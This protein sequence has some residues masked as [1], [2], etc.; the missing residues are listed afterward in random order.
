MTE[1]NFYR[2]PELA[3]RWNRTTDDLLRLAATGRLRL[4]VAFFVPNGVHN[5]PVTIAELSGRYRVERM[6]YDVM[7]DPHHALFWLCSHDVETLCKGG[8]VD[9]L[10]AYTLDGDLVIFEWPPG[11][12]FKVTRESVVVLS[13]D[14]EDPPSLRTEKMVD[15]MERLQAGDNTAAEEVADA[16]L[17][18]KKEAEERLA[19][20]E[21]VEAPTPGDLDRKETQV[22]EI[23]AHLATLDRRI[24]VMRGDMSDD[25]AA[26]LDAE[27][28]QAPSA[29]ATA[30]QP[31]PASRH[32]HKIGRGELGTVLGL[33]QKA[34]I[35]PLDAA[36][37]WVKLRELARQKPPPYP[38][39]GVD[40]NSVLYHLGMGQANYTRK[41]LG[42]WL[43]RVKALSG[44]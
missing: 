2:L 18:A 33:A 11:T 19:T 44:A 3:A 6:L 17:A 37:V 12:G 29:P 20:W 23:S 36:A 25:D 21:A 1:R 4:S 26:A 22:R 16:L 28:P 9:L 10:R 7:P 8:D 40:A 38:L 27:T 43:R 39:A 42:D 41:N 5:L 15:M 14:A 35:D 13:R 24:R 32:T 34:A 31:R 30:Q